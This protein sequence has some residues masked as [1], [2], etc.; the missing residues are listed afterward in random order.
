VSNVL[1]NKNGIISFQEITSGSYA[2]LWQIIEGGYKLLEG[3]THKPF[4]N[5]NFVDSNDA[6]LV[7]KTDEP[8]FSA[9]RYTPLSKATLHREFA[10]LYSDESVIKFANKY[11]TLGH[12]EM[13]ASSIG[14]KISYAESLTLWK[15]ESRDMGRLLTIWDMAV[16]GDAGKLGQLVNWPNAQRVLI[17]AQMIYDQ[18]HREWRIKPWSLSDRAI[19][20]G[21]FGATVATDDE[22]GAILSRWRI[23]DVVDPAKYYVLK[24]LNEK[25]KEH[26]AP[27]VFLPEDKN[28]TPHK[29][30]L[31]PDSLLAAL[32]VLFLMEVTGR[33]RVRR[34]D[35]CGNWKELK[36]NRPVFYC[37]I[38]CK[39]AAY[40]KRK[41]GETAITQT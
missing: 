22:N 27:K 11:G 8:S 17:H 20:L 10:R 26:V 21:V 31:V 30:Y 12:L 24:E 38:A 32:W 18:D 6:W 28:A 41:K 16:R 15:N 37:S 23:H 14:G 33:T 2:F 35:N 29:I 34:C 1:S 19:P 4:L 36:Y 5:G 9:H 40:R 25:L 39:Q 7:R 3:S 13:V